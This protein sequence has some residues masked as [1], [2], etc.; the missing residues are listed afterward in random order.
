LLWTTLGDPLLD[1]PGISEMEDPDGSAGWEVA[2]GQWFDVRC[3]L[4]SITE[5]FRDSSHFAFVHRET[6]GDV[7]PEIPAYTVRGNGWRLEWDLT[8]T[9][10]SAGAPED[11]TPKYRFGDTDAPGS[12]GEP[13]RQL[14]HYRFELPSLSYVYT[15]HEGGTGRLVCQAAAP[16]D[17][18]G[19]TC[20]V[21]WFVAADAG[22]RRRYGDLA[23]QV[24]IESRVFAEDVPIVEALDPL[25]A[26]LDLEGQAHVRA[27]RYSVAYRKLYREMLDRFRQ[28]KESGAPF[29]ASQMAPAI[30]S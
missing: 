10:G 16:I 23:A 14:L 20:R 25:E 22:F 17:T 6:F 27:D 11:G 9:F 28:A 13:E 21:F 7:S 26:P 29:V 4:R 15:E 5:N 24:G 8:V 1:P 19:V 30:T 18:D 12:G 3:G 2:G